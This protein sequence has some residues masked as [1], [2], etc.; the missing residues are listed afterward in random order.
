V[1]LKQNEYK[2]WSLTAEGNK[3]CDEGTPE[4]ILYSMIPE[5]GIQKSEVPAD[6]YKFG[7][8]NGMK[9]K[10]MNIFDKVLIKRTVTFKINI[11]DG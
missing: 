7:F 5:E 10:W 8:Q 2:Y 9:K 3:N 1:T 4:F 11:K 6:L